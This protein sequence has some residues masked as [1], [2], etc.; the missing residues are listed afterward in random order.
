MPERHGTDERLRT[1]DGKL[2]KYTKVIDA[3]NFMGKE[4]WIFIHAFPVS[5]GNIVV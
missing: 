4:G 3:L 2:R 5:N 1:Y